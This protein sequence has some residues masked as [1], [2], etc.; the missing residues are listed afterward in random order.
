[1]IEQSENSWVTE[2]GRSAARQYCKSASNKIQSMDELWHE[3]LQCQADVSG[4]PIARTANKE[5][6]EYLDYY[7]K[8]DVRVK[9]FL[10]EL[11]EIKT[12]SARVGLSDFD[13][14]SINGIESQLH[15]RESKIRILREMI[16]FI[17]NINVVTGLSLD[18]NSRSV[19]QA[20]DY[21]R[22]LSAAYNYPVELIMEQKIRTVSNIAAGRKEQAYKIREIKEQIDSEWAA[23]FYK[24]N[25]SE[26]LGR[27]RTDYT[28]FFKTFSS[29][30]KQDKRTLAAL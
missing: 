20:V 15:S 21:I 7:N 14:R 8:S 17:D 23:D 24:L 26:L 10:V 28:S 29:A 19:R 9:L 18:Y 6:Q 12:D 30:Y 16:E 27:F 3:L 4:D 11:E 25:A 22:V 13:I 1:M 5:I 2:N